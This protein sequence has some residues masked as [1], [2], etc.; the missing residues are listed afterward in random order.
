MDMIDTHIHLW[1]LERLTY[2]FLRELDPAEQA[3]LGDY[4]AIRKN[5]LIENYLVDSHDSGVVKA[6]HVQA[7]LGHPDPAEETAWL[8]DIADAH[9]IPQGII[10]FC[11]LRR[12]DVD[13]VLDRHQ[14][15]ANFRGIRMLGTGGMLLESSFLWG[16]SRLAARGLVYD[17][18]A[19]V[20]D[21]PDAVRLAA[22][23]S[24]TPIVL[25]HTGLPMER[26]PEYF[27]AWRAGMRELSAAD[28][29]VC[30]ISGLGM[31]DHSWSVA[32]I[33]PW[34]EAC[35]E[36][37]GPS[38]CMFG[39]NWPVDSLYSSHRAVVDAYREIVRHLGGEEQQKILVKTAETTYGI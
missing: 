31:T 7:A 5:Y 6:V 13:A 23:F 14:Q 22:K 4:N 16:F 20:K 2:S 30:K 34:V 26:T 36:V 29:V 28:N 35:I 15:Y 38:R 27:Q 11:D 9:A 17:L 12:G 21:F 24:N 3:V 8:Q 1:D 32:T 39:T 18:E 37:F 19:T 25:E 10:G 33:R